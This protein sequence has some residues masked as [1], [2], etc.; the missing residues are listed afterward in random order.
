VNTSNFTQNNLHYHP[1]SFNAP[2]IQSSTSPTEDT[3]P[4]PA[5]LIYFSPHINVVAGLE[6]VREMILNISW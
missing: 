6:H 3:T 5:Q 4:S 2:T 1:T